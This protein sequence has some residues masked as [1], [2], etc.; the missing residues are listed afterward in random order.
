MVAGAGPDRRASH[1]EGDLDP[2][3]EALGLVLRELDFSQRQLMHIITRLISKSV[4]SDSNP[5]EKRMNCGE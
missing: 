2:D 4:G 1:G 3:I 5:R